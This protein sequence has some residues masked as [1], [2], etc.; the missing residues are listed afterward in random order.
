MFR[1]APIPTNS[2]GLV[3]QYVVSCLGDVP[4]VGMIVGDC[5]SKDC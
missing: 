5:G 4:T 3:V 2:E 1:G